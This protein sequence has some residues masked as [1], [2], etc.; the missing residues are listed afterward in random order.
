MKKPEI[1][2]HCD[3][4]YFPTRRGAQ[5]FCSASCKSRYWYL[6]NNNTQEITKISHETK[7]EKQN[8]KVETMSFAGIGNAAAGT[9]VVDTLKHVFA[10][11]ENKPATKKDIQELKAL[12]LNRYLPVN[13]AGKDAYGRSPFYDVE[14]GNVVYLQQ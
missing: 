13:N 1:C 14:T 3:G 7:P 2:E 12:M 4:E 11:P 8:N 6:K 5:K 10:S 9:A